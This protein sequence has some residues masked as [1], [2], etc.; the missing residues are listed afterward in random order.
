MVASSVQFGVP[1]SE[2]F[3]V[4]VLNGVATSKREGLMSP[5]NEVDDSAGE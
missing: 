3:I 5:W 1:D 4:L 2:V